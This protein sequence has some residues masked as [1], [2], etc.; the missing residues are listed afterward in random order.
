MSIVFL[1]SRIAKCTLFHDF[2]EDDG[3][4]L[5]AAAST[6]HTDFVLPA[7]LF[8][9]PT[10]MET[11]KAY[12]G[13]HSQYYKVADIAQALVVMESEDQR[14]MPAHVQHMLRQASSSSLLAAIP[15]YESKATDVE[16]VFAEERAWTLWPHGL[17]APMHDIRIRR[18]QVEPGSGRISLSASQTAETIERIVERLLAADEAAEG[19]RVAL[20]H[21]GKEERTERVFEKGFLPADGATTTAEAYQPHGRVDFE[22]E[23]YSSDEDLAVQLELD[24]SQLLPAS[25]SGGDYF[26]AP[27]LQEDGTAAAG[28]GGISP[29]TDAPSKS[30]LDAMIRQLTEMQDD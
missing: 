26:V 6:E 10:V 11:V 5:S 4:G 28:S 24:L 21:A 27:A 9:L 18:R 20:K 7:V 16:T 25:T 19:V 15:D 22:E 2:N 12:R 13:D 8:D 30:R 29:V 3:D 17:T 23:R 14:A 1:N